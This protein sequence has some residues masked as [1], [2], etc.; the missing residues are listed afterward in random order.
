MLEAIK[1][2]TNWVLVFIVTV[3]LLLPACIIAVFTKK[4]A[5][6]IIRFWAKGALYIL[7]I[8]VEVLDKNSGAYPNPAYILLT[9]NQT[10]LIETFI[11]FAYVPLFF[12]TISNIE[13]ALIP[14]VG[15]VQVLMGGVVII[16]QNK[17]QSK[18]GIE[19]AKKILR[20]GISIGMSIEGKRSP[21]GSIQPYKKGPIILA[22]DNHTTI[23]PLIFKDVYER[24]PYGEWKVKPGKI[25]FIF[26][27]AI[28]TKPYN[29]NNRDQLIYKLQDVAK[30]EIKNA[31]C[32]ELN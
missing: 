28:D 27:D 19:S 6:K 11:V 23:V 8:K 18:Q 31:D 29:I 1:N 25:K 24:M 22:M 7:K 15:W 2:I 9:L 20:K 14:F 4:I 3:I 32:D 16:R 10:S 30:S 5:F 17:K 13:Y 26:G 21:D 12:V